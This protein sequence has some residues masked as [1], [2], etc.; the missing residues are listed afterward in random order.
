MDGNDDAVTIYKDAKAV[1]PTDMA[2]VQRHGL[3]DMF[4]Q[5][6]RSIKVELTA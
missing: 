6:T 3:G 5:I 2:P 1:I 4:S